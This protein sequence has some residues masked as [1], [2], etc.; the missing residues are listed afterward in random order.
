[1]TVVSINIR[2]LFN[3]Q[4]DALIVQILFCQDGTAFHPDSASKR[5]SKSAWNLP[6][7]NVQ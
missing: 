1:L 6:M 4:P 7:P 2:F 5:S 3:N